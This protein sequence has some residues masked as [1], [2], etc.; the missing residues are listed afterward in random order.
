MTMAKNTFDPNSPLIQASITSDGGNSWPVVDELGNPDNRSTTL[1]PDYPESEAVVHGQ[2][3][4]DLGSWATNDSTIDDDAEGPYNVTL[5]EP[6]YSMQMPGFPDDGTG[7]EGD[8]PMPAPPPGSFRGHVNMTDP[9]CVRGP[10]SL[11]GAEDFR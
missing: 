10:Q 11:L 3:D 7:P 6:D 2:L 5:P 9:Q 4:S 1:R 8:A